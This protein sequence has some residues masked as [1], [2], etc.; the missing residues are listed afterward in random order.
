M[1]LNLQKLTKKLYLLIIF[2]PKKISLLVAQKGEIFLSLRDLMLFKQCLTIK[3]LPIV[4]FMLLHMVFVQLQ[5]RELLLFI[6]SIPMLRNLKM[7]TYGTN[8]SSYK[9]K[10]LFQCHLTNLLKKKPILL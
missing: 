9:V 2:G 10:K 8:V 3:G 6:G 1:Y 7:P 5:K 4:Y